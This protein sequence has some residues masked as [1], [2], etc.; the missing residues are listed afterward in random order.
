MTKFFRSVL[1]ISSIVTA[2]TLATSVRAITVDG[3]LDPAYGSALAT[4]TVN[5]SYGDA[6][7]PGGDSVNG[8]E[9]DAAYG[10]I[11]NNNLYLFMAGNFQNNG[12]NVLVFIQAKSGGQSTLNITG[13]WNPPSDLNGSTF[14]PGFAPTYMFDTDEYQGTLYTSTFGLSSS[15]SA[16]NYLGQITI[17]KGIGSGT[18]GGISIGL[19]NTNTAGVNPNANSGA[20]PKAALAVGVGMELAIPLS[21]LGYSSGNIEVM[22]MIAGIGD[23]GISNQSLPGQPY[24]T[25]YVPN[26]F[27]A[28]YN[29]YFTISPTVGSSLASVPE[30]SSVSLVVVGLL[31]VLG[32]VRRRKTQANS[33]R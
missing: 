14:F 22:E 4:Q 10:T 20:N 8:S 15:G 11:Q 5:T 6:T 19:V 29:Q 28:N 7:T 32:L 9:L 13:G 18:V 17:T 24:G 33:L 21:T 1:L 26:I 27:S 31:G 25:S 30:P 3:Y 2:A 16:N 23:S 12:N